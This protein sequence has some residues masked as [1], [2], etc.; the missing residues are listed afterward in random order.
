MKSIFAA[1]LVAISVSAQW[2]EDST[3]EESTTVE[4]VE[5]PSFSIEDLFEKNEDGRW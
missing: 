1:A 2:E 4:Y 3:S 5:E